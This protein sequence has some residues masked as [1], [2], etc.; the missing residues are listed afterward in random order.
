MAVNMK[1]TLSTLGKFHSFDLARQLYSRGALRAIY[2]AYPAF[3]LRGE[4]LP[5]RLVHTF[6]WLHAP[7]MAFPRNRLSARANQAWEYLDRI[8]F[9]RYVS[10]RMPECDVFVGLSSS[11]LRSGRAAQRRG[12]VYVCDRGSSHIR[13]Q[14]G[15]LREEH[16]RW[17]L[18]FAI[19]PR[20]IAREEAEYATA[21]CITVPSHFAVRSF[22][23]AGVPKEKLRRLPYGVDLS[24][25]DAVGR[26][27]PNRFDVLFVGGMSLRKGIPYLI[28]A[29]R[30]L[31]HPAKSLTFV[32]SASHGLIAQ[33]KKHGI[34]EDSARV[35]GSVPQGELKQ[36]M[37]KSHVM[38]LPSVEDGFGMV[39]AQAMACGCPVIGSRNTGTEDILS[40]DASEGF[41]VPIRDSEAIARR[42]QQ[43]ADDADMRDR[44]S[45]AALDRVKH[46]GGWRDYG[47]QALDAYTALRG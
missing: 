30:T 41:V 38:V 46:L 23:E 15:L 45:R 19:D 21:D 31:Q 16:A 42:L 3:K 28:Q 10:L 26:P 9:D 17:G 24:R 35:V 20:V 12:A 22:I 1:V 47:S 7:F 6:P 13:Y 18:P 4:G 34:W 14:D 8:S 2:S 40:A 27:D 36:I 33:L 25:F 44:M 11:S 43:L 29:Y 37:S 32:G 39:L 5:S